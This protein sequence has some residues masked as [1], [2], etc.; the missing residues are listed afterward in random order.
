MRNISLL[1]LKDLALYTTFERFLEGVLDLRQLQV[2]IE[3][4]LLLSCLNGSFDYLL[5]LSNSL[6]CFNGSIAVV[7]RV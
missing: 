5:K 6:R 2:L 3:V 4:L 7:L 1:F